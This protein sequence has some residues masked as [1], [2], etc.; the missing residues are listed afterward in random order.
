MQLMDTTASDM[1]VTHPFSPWASID[2]GVKYLRLMLNRFNGDE[3]L[4]LAS[5]NAG[6]AAV[7][8]YN[9]IPR[10]GRPLIM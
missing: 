7:E 1:G 8:K 4:A 2:G 9:G 6:P 3:K 10:T 5:Y